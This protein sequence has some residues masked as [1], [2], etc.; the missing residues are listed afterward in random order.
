MAAV[1]ETCGAKLG[2]GRRLGGNDQCESCEDREGAEAVA[3]QQARAHARANYQARAERIAFE[4]GG[5]VTRLRALAEQAGLDRDEV[6]QA[7]LD[8]Y[9][10]LLAKAID[11]EFLTDDEERAL[12]R[13]SSLLELP[14][15]E[16]AAAVKSHGNRL[17][18]ARMNAGR[19]TPIPHASISL[20][21][22]EEAYLEVATK[23]LKEVVHRQ[24][25]GGI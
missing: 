18:I 14:G 12:D 10:M 20:K 3:A 23:L 25:Q 21:P 5:G 1:C 9:R 19:M 16:Q 7:H 22:G 11:D 15:D 24:T 2:I 17:W 4:D 6:A 13:T 8:A